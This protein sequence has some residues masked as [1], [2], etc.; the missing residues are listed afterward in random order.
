MRPLMPPVQT[1]DNLF[2][3]G[4][5]LTG[6]LGTIVDAE[7]LNNEQ[8]AIRDTQSELIAILTAAAME[9][10]ST[11]G[12]LLAALNKLYAPL[13]DTLG[14]LS[15]LVGGANK[16]PYFTAANAAA[17]T[18]L[19]SIGRDIIGKATV[20]EVLTYLQLG[21]AAKRDVGT[22]ENQI[23]DMSSFG[24]G[25]GWSQLPNGK[26]LQW[27]TYTGSATTGT[28]NFPVPFPISVG[29]VIMSLSGTSA[30]AGSIAYVL[31]DDN[32]LSKTSFFFRR[33]GAQV[34]FNW[35]CI[36]E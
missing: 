22:G 16:L 14:A 19:S 34:R 7:H 29:R 31:Q 17:L 6:E 25:S 21:E 28:I 24:S 33:A 32:S 1:P 35:F 13:N 30:D 12:Q 18:A 9:P 5:P 11:A 2:H 15:T 4:N 26:L 3:D 8:A 27:G 10:E 20:A 23:P 36:G